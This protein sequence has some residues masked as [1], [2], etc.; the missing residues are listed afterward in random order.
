MT[1]QISIQL[2]LLNFIMEFIYLVEIIYYYRS[3]VENFNLNLHFIGTL[4]NVI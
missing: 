2:Q 4:I 1:G 3:P